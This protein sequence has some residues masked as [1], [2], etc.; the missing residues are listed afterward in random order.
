[1]FQFNSP[2]VSLKILI[3][4]VSD[5]LRSSVFMYCPDRYGYECV[6]LAK[7]IGDTTNYRHTSLIHVPFCSFSKWNYRKVFKS[8]FIGNFILAIK[9]IS[10]ILLYTQC[11]SLIHMFSKFLLLKVKGRWVPKMW[12]LGSHCWM[13]SPMDMQEWSL[14]GQFFP[15][16][17]LMRDSVQVPD[18]RLHS[19]K[20]SSSPAGNASVQRTASWDFSTRYSRSSGSWRI[21]TFGLIWLV[22]LCQGSRWG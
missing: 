5:S 4:L 17:C 12:S 14:S 21:I 18:P 6:Q 11:C 8:M 22:T 1:M 7:T 20:A 10:R 19:G 9:I 15:S 13:D 16:S 3:N 2:I